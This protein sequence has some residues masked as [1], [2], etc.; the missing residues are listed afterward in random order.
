MHSIN[1]KQYDLIAKQYA[2][3][4]DMIKRYVLIPTFLNLVGNVKKRSVMDLA[5][6][7]GFFT[8]I[9]AKMKPSEIIGLDISKKLLKL[10]QLREDKE[11]LGISYINKDVFKFSDYVKKFNIVTAVYLL[12]Y[13]K[14]KKELFEMCKTANQLLEKDGIF[15]TITL[16]PAVKPTK[17]IEYERRIFNLNGKNSF[18][19]GGRVK[20]EMHEKIKKPFGFVCYYWS[21]KTYEDCLHKAGFRKIKWVRPTI[22]EEGIK[23]FGR[24]YWER[25][26]KNPSPTGIICRK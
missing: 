5:C 22:S 8:R 14:T 20:Y 10:A 18:K 25:F 6:G 13:A 3:M 12:N 9:L 17:G 23:K 15:A 21:K 1:P 2:G 26:K 11:R 16:S 4:R 7:G 24:E 19:N